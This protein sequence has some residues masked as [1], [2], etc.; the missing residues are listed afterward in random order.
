MGRSRGRRTR[1]GFTPIRAAPPGGCVE[2]KP[3]PL[4]VVF[5]IPR[6]VG[7]LPLFDRPVLLS[8]IPPG[9]RAHQEASNLVVLSPCEVVSIHGFSLPRRCVRVT[10]AAWKK[11]CPWG[12]DPPS[13]VSLFDRY[14]FPSA[15]C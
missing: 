5:M 8:S 4:C 12:V 1:V 6:I 11:Q 2:G 9:M 3:R 14:R 13:D 10:E 15:P 7:L